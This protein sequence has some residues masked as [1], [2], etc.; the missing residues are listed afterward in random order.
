VEVDVQRTADGVVV[1]SHDADLMRLAREPLVISESRFEDLRA[2]DVGRLFSA[3]FTG[4]R[5]PT[6]E[7][8]IG[9]CRGKVKLIVE[10]KSYR[11]D[12][13]QL[14]ADVVQLFR[15]HD[16][17]SEAVIMSLEYGEVQ[18]VERLDTSITTGFVASAALGNISQLNV[19]FLAVSQSMATNTF[20]ATA[21]S[22]GKEVYVW[23]IDDRRDMATM[24]DRGANNIITNDPAALVSVLEERTGLTNA[25][26]IL[27]RFKSIYIK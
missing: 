20:I 23:T 4:E 7:E 5:L 6:L 12:S 9:E 8:V 19:N 16:L 13:A 17:Y 22:Y 3:E 24:I 27:L 21:H 11:G 2:A 26:R 14:V 15:S 25:E 18:Q 1:L 10:L